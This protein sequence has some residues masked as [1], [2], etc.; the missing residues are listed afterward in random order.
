MIKAGIIGCGHVA[1]MGHLPFL[2]ENPHV[3][4]VATCDANENEAASTAKRWG[5]PHVYSDYMRMFDEAGLD[6]VVIATPPP[7]HADMASAAAERGIHVL[8]EKPMA[9]TVA[10]CD[11][12]IEAADKHGIILQLGH[13]KRFNPTFQ[14]V[15][16]IIDEGMLGQIFHVATH[17]NTAVRLDPETLCPPAHRAGYMWRWKD[18][19]V[20]G[21]ILQDHVP[22]YLD[23]WRWWTGAELVSVCSELLNVR[24]DLIGDEELGGLYEDFG[25]VSMKFNN[26]CVGSFQTGT[27]GRGIS[28]ILHMGSG[29]GE[30]TEYGVIMGTRGHLVFDAFFSS[31]PELSKIMVFSL[32]RKCTDYRGW[33]QVEME[34]PWRSPGGPLAP[35]SNTHFL[36]KR[37]MDHFFDCIRN[38]TTPAVTGHDGRATIVGIEAVYRSHKTDQKVRVEA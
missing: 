38:G 32:E 2:W 10:E 37:Q 13:Q 15:K 29:I 20:G 11:R 21:G 12:I 26:G 19:S 14:K 4:F 5:V 35:T 28:P 36:F 25:A 6:A 33:F 27:V 24:G 34:E 22:H 1:W 7:S 16:E 17:W 8:L 31:S 9:P 30:W 18:P 3:D 23:L